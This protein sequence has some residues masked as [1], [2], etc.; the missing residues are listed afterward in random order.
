MGTRTTAPFEITSWDAREAEAPAQGHAFGSAVIAKTYKGELAG[1]AVGEFVGCQVGDTSGGYV[2]M[3]RF[4]G[5]LDGRAGTFLL[6]H[7]AVRGGPDESFGHVVPGTGTGELSGLSGT[8]VIEHD[9][10]GPLLVLDYE[11]G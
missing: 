7:G 6:Q 2:C 8:V 9:E 3:E 10:N 11:L 1:T 4:T 5:T